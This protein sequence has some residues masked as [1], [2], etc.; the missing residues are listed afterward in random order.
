MVQNHYNYYWDIT[1][2]Y[3]RLDKKMT[4]AFTAVYQMLEE[5]KADNVDMRTAAYL[6][7]VNRVAEAMKMR[8]WV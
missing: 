8:G 2:V 3:E 6:V 5:R 1:T 7:A 4:S